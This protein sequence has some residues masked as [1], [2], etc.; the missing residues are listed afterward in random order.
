MVRLS[1]C[2]AAAVILLAVCCSAP[3]QMFAA[4]VR[5]TTW[6]LQWF[7]NGSPKDVPP[8]EQERHIAAAADVLRSLDPDIILLQEVR[9]YDTCA[10]LAEAIQPHTYQVAVCSAFKEP[11]QS[12]FGRQQIA[13]LAKEPAQ[14]AWSESWKSAEGVDPP[15]G[16]AFSWFDFGGANIGV[17]CVHLKSNLITHGDKA[18][19]AALNIRKREEAA[20]QLLDHVNTVLPAKIPL[21]QTV[22]VGGDFNTNVDQP[23]FVL[24]KTLKFFWNGGFIDCAKN[25]PIAQ[26]VTHR[27]N[28]GYPPAT[29]DYLFC[30]DAIP[31][32]PQ[33]TPTDASDHLPVTCNF[34]ISGQSPLARVPSQNNRDA[35][36]T[37]DVEIGKPFDLRSVG[38]PHIE[39]YVVGIDLKTITMRTVDYEHLKQSTV[40]NVAVTAP[41]EAS[42]Q[43]GR[44]AG[45]A[46]VRSLIFESENLR[47]YFVE[48]M[49]TRQNH[50][51]LDIVRVP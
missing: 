48:D 26:R 47:V 27:A 22:L 23:M 45:F 44:S 33:F 15:R 17:Y 16:F 10:Q 5:V 41:T 12:G 8:A 28:N 29:F 2:A 13:I 25:L 24:E 39:L 14:A 7:P 3:N 51:R 37:E 19:A 46:P 50:A 6:N 11:F 20:K 32:R 35:V 38:G 31:A 43:A 40:N 21:I 9:D 42:Y 36:S 18:A 1:R 34:A 49:R 4:T 30:K